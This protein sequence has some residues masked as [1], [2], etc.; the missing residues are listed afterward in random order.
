[1]ENNRRDFLKTVAAI[2]ATTN[3]FVKAGK[4]LGAQTNRGRPNSWVKDLY[5]P[6]LQVRDGKVAI[7][8]GPGWG[9]TVNPKWLETAERHVSKLS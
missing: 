4:V 9:V 6:E 5:H 1:M 2:A 7:P 3:H 8:D